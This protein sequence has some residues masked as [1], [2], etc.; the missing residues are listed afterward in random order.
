MDRVYEQKLTVY[1]TA[2]TAREKTAPKTRH[3]Q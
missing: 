3:A 1:T 2:A